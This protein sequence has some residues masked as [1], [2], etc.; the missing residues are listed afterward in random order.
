[1]LWNWMNM[2]MATPNVVTT[3]PRS[4]TVSNPPPSQTPDNSPY[5]AIADK[6]PTAGPSNVGD[7]DNTQQVQDMGKGK[8]VEQDK[9]PDNVEPDNGD[10]GWGN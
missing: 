6:P 5:R 8:E 4:C 10:N 7:C 2:K 3:T 1:M 9:E